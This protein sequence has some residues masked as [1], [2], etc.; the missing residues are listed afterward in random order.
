MSGRETGERG[1][2]G[3]AL[4]CCF[5]RAERRG[6]H[7]SSASA[8]AQLH[9]NAQSVDGKLQ[10]HPLYQRVGRARHAPGGTPALAVKIEWL[11]GITIVIPRS[12]GGKR[13][14]GRRG[15]SRTGAT[16]LLSTSAASAVHQTLKALADM[17]VRW[18]GCMPPCA[19]SLC[20]RVLSAHLA[21]AHTQSAAALRRKRRARRLRRSSPSAASVDA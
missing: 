14:Q 17:R 16:R 11:R 1:E 13:V 10:Q 21:S 20:V 3:S 6:G 15:M 7:T 5:R 9:A 2:H 4:V 18:G 19:A 8:H 12:G